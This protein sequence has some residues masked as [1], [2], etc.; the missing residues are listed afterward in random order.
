MAEGFATWANEYQVKHNAVDSLLKILKEHG[1]SN[2][3]STV[4]TLLKTR[5]VNTE[6]KSGMEYIHLGL[7][8]E[9]VKNLDTYPLEI[10]ENVLEISLNFDGLPL[11]TSSTTSLWPV[12]CA[13]HLQPVKVFPVTLTFVNSNQQISIFC[14]KQ[15]EI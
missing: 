13:L 5:E 11:F 14:K 4:R 7:N 3:P 12:L 6:V 1:H 10:R 8:D 15:S 9:I 2:L